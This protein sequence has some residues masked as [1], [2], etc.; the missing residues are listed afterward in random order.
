MVR[1]ALTYGLY[2]LLLAQTV[3]A[4]DGVSFEAKV[5]KQELGINERLRVDFIMNEDGD[6][7]V[8]PSFDQFHLLGG[9]NQSISNSWINGVRSYSKTY[10]YFLSPKNKG[11]FTIGQASIEVAGSVYKTQPIKITVT[12]AVEQPKDPNDPEYVADQNMELVAELSNPNPYLNEAVSVVYKLYVSDDVYLSGLNILDQPKYNNF[13]SQI[14]PINKLEI[15][16]GTYKNRSYNY[17]VVSRAVLYPQKEGQ[18]TIEPLS[19]DISLEVPSQQRN[20][21]GGFL[22]QTV[23]RTVTAPSRTIQVKP[24]PEVGKPENFSG[25][26]GTFDFSM[27]ASP[28]VLKAGEAFQVKLKVSGKGNL[29]LLKMPEFQLPSSLEMYEP[30]RKENINTSLT[31]MSGDVTVNYTVVPAFRGEY[32]LPEVHFDYFDLASKSYKSI[33][34]ESLTI[35]VTE[36]PVNNG[37]V[38]NFSEDKTPKSNTKA[39]SGFKTQTAFQPI[40]TPNFF[41]SKSFWLWL[42]IPLLMLPIVLLFKRRR[43]A[44]SADVVGAKS[45]SDWKMAH[46]YLK[47]ASSALGDSKRFYEAL[48]RALYNVLKSKLKVPITALNKE[49][50]SQILAEKKC[51]PTTISE[52]NSLLQSCEFARY[53]PSALE[54]MNSDY[55]KAA[56]LIVELSK[57]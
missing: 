42:F 45:K 47:E 49:G 39:F 57:I 21:F 16:R 1:Y 12:A 24:L 22:R 30:E 3:L 37:A 54:S 14:I 36:G 34:S 53:T 29:K 19:L 11:V 10:S 55:E 26:V 46:R 6:N 32:P 7:F 20:M 33:S 41:N 15:E 56:A 13:W 9:P 28:E 23:R 48:E 44:L 38:S 4:Q 43:E 35:E 25:A 18:L 31:G 5:S 51:K 50:I 2:F 40:V 17:V 52:L 8:P 27:T